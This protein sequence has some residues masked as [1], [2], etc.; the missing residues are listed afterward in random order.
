MN[1]IEG[2]PPGHR[3][4]NKTLSQVR[5]IASVVIQALTISKQVFPGQ[6][7]PSQ[8]PQ[9]PNMIPILKRP[10]PGQLGLPQPHPSFKPG[11]TRRSCKI[12][13]HVWI[14]QYYPFV[15]LPYRESDCLP[16]RQLLLV[17][18]HAVVAMSI[19]PGLYIRPVEP[20]CA[21]RSRNS[22][23]TCTGE[24]ILAPLQPDVGAR[25]HTIM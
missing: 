25:E 10:H 18:G 6:D 17:M 14:R 15:G 5:I 16:T 11:P 23:Y 21:L 7:R 24:L 1:K 2:L 4:Y 19:L 12:K 9:A 22:G 20:E 8:D 3:L 13:Q